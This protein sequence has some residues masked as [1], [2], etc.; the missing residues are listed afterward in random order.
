MTDTQFKVKEMRE[1]AQQR[2][3]KLTQK[4][5]RELVLAVGERSRSE[6][7]DMEAAGQLPT[8]VWVKVMWEACDCCP[9]TWELVVGGTR[10][11]E[12]SFLSWL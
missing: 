1:A 10:P 4:Q 3:F 2:G 12:S 7:Q 8:G 11:G 6:W 5:A 9:P